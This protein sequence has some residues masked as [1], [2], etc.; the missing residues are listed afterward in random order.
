MVLQRD[1]AAVFSTLAPDLAAKGVIL[2]DLDTAVQKYPDLVEQHMMAGLSHPARTSIT[3]L[4]AAFWSGGVFLYVPKGVH[5]ALP[6][7]VTGL[8]RRAGLAF[9]S[10]SL[11]V[12]EPGSSVGFIEQFGSAPEE[13]RQSYHSGVVEVLV[14]ERAEVTYADVQNWG[15]GVISVVHQRA[16]VRR[17]ATM[18]WVGAHLGAKA[19]HSRIHTALA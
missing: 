1:S 10:H 17:D 18:R 4:H 2:T 6:F 11:I 3:A 14:G 15:P 8:A 9:F 5:I 12:A 16:D 13:M 19:A 7:V